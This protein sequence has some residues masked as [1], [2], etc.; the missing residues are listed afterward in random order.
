LSA[1]VLLPGDNGA[2]VLSYQGWDGGTFREGSTLSAPVIEISGNWIK[3]GNPAFNIQF[4][5]DAA[6]YTYAFQ[7]GAGSAVTEA[8][9]NAGYSGNYISLGASQTASSQNKYTMG[10]VSSDGEARSLS[11]GA[12]PGLLELAIGSLY[13]LPTARVSG[14]GQAMYSTTPTT[15]VYPAGLSSVATSAPAIDPIGSA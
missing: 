13:S 6:N 5:N 12:W 9:F 3:T 11:L 1:L 7:F 4:R 8:N 14:W 15:M 10:M 2:A